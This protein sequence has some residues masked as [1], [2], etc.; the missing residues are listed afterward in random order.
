MGLSCGFTKSKYTCL[1][2]WILLTIDI[3]TTF[4]AFCTYCFLLISI[5]GKIALSMQYLSVIIVTQHIC[6]TMFFIILDPCFKTNTIFFKNISIAT[7]DSVTPSTYG[8]I[9]Q[10]IQPEIDEDDCFQQDPWLLYRTENYIVVGFRFVLL[11]L[12]V[13]VMCVFSDGWNC[14]NSYVC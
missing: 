6:L 1:I 14:V 10:P 7:I 11:A 13:A 9:E 5:I 8:S 2:G 4:L 12:D 3:C